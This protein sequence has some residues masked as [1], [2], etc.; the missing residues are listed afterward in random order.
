MATARTPTLKLESAGSMSL[1]Y[2]DELTDIDDGDTFASG[3]T[4]RIIA[5]WFNA[6]SNPTT[7]TSN[8]V[9]VTYTYSS[10]AIVFQCGEANN[11]GKLYILTLS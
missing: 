2:T 4:N 11:T 9:D 8:G 5:A 6:S 3:L 10:G 7:Q 1:Y